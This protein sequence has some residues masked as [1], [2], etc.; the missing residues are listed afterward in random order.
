MDKYLIFRKYILI[1]TSIA[2]AICLFGHNPFE[3]LIA[4]TF[5][6]FISYFLLKE[7]YPQVLFFIML[8]QWLQVTAKLFYAR[9]FN[10]RFE[11]LIL[12]PDTALETFYISIIGLY[13]ITFGIHF[14]IKDID[15]KS[16]KS[17]QP[18]EKI[19]YRINKVV[20]FY[21]VYSVILYFTSDY[22]WYFPSLTQILFL[23]INL[24]WGIL[25]FMFYLMFKNKQYN[26]LI[27]IFVTLEIIVS[28]SNFFSDF[29]TYLFFIFFA[30]IGANYKSFNFKKFSYGLLV[31]GIL[32][33]MGILWTAVKSDYRGYITNGQ[34]VQT[35][36]IGTGESLTYLAKLLEDLDLKTY[37]VS[38]SL[39]VE[40]IS[41][42][43]FFS[44]VRGR[45][46][47]VIP[48][49]NGML[50]LALLEHLLMPRFIFTN[51]PALDDS[52]DTQTF[53]GLNVSGVLQ[54][55]SIGMGYFAYLYIDYGPILMMPFLFFWGV[56]IGF[57]FITIINKSKNE[58][59]QFTLT[60]PLF[61]VIGGFETSLYKVVGGLLIY[62]ITVLVFIKYF[63]ILLDIVLKK[64]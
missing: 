13:V 40:R 3:C 27:I 10:I 7:G 61:I 22:I 60:A 53:T 4:L 31:I 47:S 41:Y 45:V 49:E 51:K 58:L 19:N 16:K 20:K 54:G 37:K 44:V 18:A 52:R 62:F 21:F 35:S 55:T 17:Q 39:L 59:W 33:N 46:P 30:Y 23:F 8:F 32:I 11:D 1:V 43:D 57:V 42:I 9:I 34:A 38:S 25:F 6:P 63:Q 64:K 36:L 12:N 26:T 29:K 50:T 28:L 56:I 24:K 48:H 5:L 15:K 2:A 14:M